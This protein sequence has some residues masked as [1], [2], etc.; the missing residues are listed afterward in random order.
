VATAKPTI[1]P[2]PKTLSPDK[3]ALLRG[4]K[5]VATNRRARHDYE[6]LETIECGVVLVGSE[7]KSLREAKVQIREAWASVEGGE[8]WLHGMHV[9][10]YGFSRDTPVVDRKRKLL[11]HK[12]QALELRTQI[13]QQGLTLIPLRIYFVH[14]LAKIELGLA[15]GRKRYDKRQALAERDAQ[16]DIDRAV[17]ADKRVNTADD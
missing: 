8:V 9:S 5:T 11:L 12:S 6:I 14:G 3:A 7:V 17:K 2:K 16:R 10:P 13:E 1:Q 4:D 15:R